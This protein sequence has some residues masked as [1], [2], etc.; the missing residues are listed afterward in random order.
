[1]A[2]AGGSYRLRFVVSAGIEPIAAGKRWIE[3][4]RPE[5]APAGDAA[6]A[7][8][9]GEFVR[10]LQSELEIALEDWH[11]YVYWRPSCGKPSSAASPAIRSRI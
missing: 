7:E 2:V 10:P 3:A 4:K 5:D 11:G 6:R 1:M 8:R 9:R